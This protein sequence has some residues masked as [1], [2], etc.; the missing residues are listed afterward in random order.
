MPVIIRRAFCLQC[1]T[2]HSARALLSSPGH[3][4]SGICTEALQTQLH[5]IAF[6]AKCPVHHCS[7]P[8]PWHRAVCH[9]CNPALFIWANMS[10]AS[11]L[12]VVYNAGLKS[13]ADVFIILSE[14]MDICAVSVHVSLATCTDI[15]SDIDHSS[16]KPVKHYL[17]GL[18]S[19]NVRPRFFNVVCENFSCIM[20]FTDH[21]S[22]M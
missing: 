7:L 11:L 1:L 16:N 15:V 4:P 18:Q 5:H 10:S 19:R 9:G 13:N 21:D 20:K 22:C 2:Q 6:R 3:L 14:L 17:I 12:Q 8:E